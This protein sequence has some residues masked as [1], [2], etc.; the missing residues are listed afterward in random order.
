MAHY[1]KP[2]TRMENLV[3]AGD[4]Y[5]PVKTK[6]TLSS[7]VRSTWLTIRGHTRSCLRQLDAGTTVVPLKFVS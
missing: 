6:G 3:E 2:N 5:V 4:S 1:T 7:T